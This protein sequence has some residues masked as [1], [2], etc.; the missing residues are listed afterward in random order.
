MVVRSATGTST[1]TSAAKPQHPSVG[2]VQE[3]I[4][5]PRDTI[6]VSS[7][8]ISPVVMLP[9]QRSQIILQTLRLVKSAFLADCLNKFL[10]FNN[11]VI[12]P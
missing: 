5:N 12:L 8:M 6:G 9:K 1:K 10:C 7:G 2:K 4:K 3:G 11:P